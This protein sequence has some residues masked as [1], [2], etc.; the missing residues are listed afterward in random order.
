M[1]MNEMPSQN[2]FYLLWQNKKMPYVEMFNDN[3][4]LDLLYYNQ[5]SG[6]KIVSSI[7]EKYQNDMKQLAKIILAKFDDKWNH[8]Y[9]ALKEEYNPVYNYNMEETL[10]RD[11]V[12]S[13]K[14]TSTD[15]SS[16]QSSSEVNEQVYGFNSTEAV[17]SN[18]SNG[19]GSSS[20]SLSNSNSKD[21]SYKG[22]EKT[23]RK[24]NIGVTTTQQMI[25]EEIEMRKHLF[26]DMIMED[27]DLVMTLQ[28]Y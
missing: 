14:G 24:G 4:D 7:A 17:D 2:I 18:K 1:K 12:N 27:I 21:T 9:E 13:S 8:I 26:Y 5:H 6:E 23:T 11:L 19:V 16:S 20:Y 10:E 22:T 15:E 25:M 3:E 28:I